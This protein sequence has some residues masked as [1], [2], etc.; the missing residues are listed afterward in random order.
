MRLP[1]S[2]ITTD[3]SVFALHQGQADQA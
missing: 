3:A 1:L 2:A